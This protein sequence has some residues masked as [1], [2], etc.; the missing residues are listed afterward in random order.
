ML[1]I[2]SLFSVMALFYMVLILGI[3][4]ASDLKEKEKKDEIVDEI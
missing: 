1:E 4:H 2:Y 3:L